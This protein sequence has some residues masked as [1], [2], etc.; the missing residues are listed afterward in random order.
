M[1]KGHLQSMEVLVKTPKGYTINGFKEVFPTLSAIQDRYYKDNSFMMQ[2]Q[3][4]VIDANQEMVLVEE[5]DFSPAVVE[6]GEA[7]PVPNE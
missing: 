4:I 5:S 1:V 2:L 7:V 3:G 6:P